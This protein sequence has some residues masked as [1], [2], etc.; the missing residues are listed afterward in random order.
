MGSYQFYQLILSSYLIADNLILGKVV[1]QP[2]PVSCAETCLKVVSE[3][4]L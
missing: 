3:P 1:T 4:Y 2:D